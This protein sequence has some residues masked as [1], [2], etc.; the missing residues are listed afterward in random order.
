MQL[1]GGSEDLRGVLESRL[2]YVYGEHPAAQLV[3][4]ANC[5]ALRLGGLPLFRLSHTHF[6][7][8]LDDV[9]KMNCAIQ[10]VYDALR[11]HGV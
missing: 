1:F 5:K 6:V 3:R 9:D 4:D 10:K 7:G 2:T 11:A 8:I